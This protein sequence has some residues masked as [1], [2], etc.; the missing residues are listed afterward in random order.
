[1]KDR[2]KDVVASGLDPMSL[3]KSR[4]KLL[5]INSDKLVSEGWSQITNSIIVVKREILRD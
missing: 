4:F 2:P 5:M 1:M 3:I